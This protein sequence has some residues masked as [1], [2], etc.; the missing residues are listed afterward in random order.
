MVRELEFSRITVRII[1]TIDN[2][3]DS[4]EQHVVSKLT[5]NT[6]D[7]LRKCLVRIEVLQLR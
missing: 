5:G 6:I 7:T 2:D 4:H 3:G 1:E